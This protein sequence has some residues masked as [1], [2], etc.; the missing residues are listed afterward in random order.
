MKQSPNENV[1]EYARR[2]RS[3]LTKA[4]HGHQLDNV[5]QVGHFINGLKVNLKALTLM[6]NPANLNAAINRAKLI[7]SSYGTINDMVPNMINN[8]SVQQTTTQQSTQPQVQQNQ[9]TPT[10]GIEDKMDELTRQMENLKINMI[11]TRSNNRSNRYI[12]NQ[13][14]IIDL[15]EIK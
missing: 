13:M 7:E 5:Y 14:D 6:D 4:T 9:Q 1:D 3:T 11:R 15:K 12:V 8:T 10:Q 2:F